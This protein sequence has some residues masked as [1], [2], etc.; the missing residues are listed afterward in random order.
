[1]TEQL[2]RPLREQYCAA[3]V[4]SCGGACQIATCNRHCSWH[5]A[6]AVSC[7]SH[8][9]CSMCLMCT[10]GAAAVQRHASSHRDTRTWCLSPRSPSMR[11]VTCCNQRQSVLHVHLPQLQFLYWSHD[12]QTKTSAQRSAAGS[13]ACH[14]RS[15]V[16]M[17]CT[18]FSNLCRLLAEDVQGTRSCCWVRAW[19]GGL[20]AATA[21]SVAT[22][23]LCNDDTDQRDR[24]RL[25]PQQYVALV[26]PRCRSG[27]RGRWKQGTE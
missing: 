19:T 12:H 26:L 22:S 16:L 1:M 4:D 10:V 14:P 6:M 13:C 17:T 24:V 27:D 3:A 15:S 23:K 20:L 5:G 21:H 25:A 2:L 8:S 7:R 11:V 18:S 9:G